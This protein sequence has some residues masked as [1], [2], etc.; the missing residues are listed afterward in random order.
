[1]ESTLWHPMQALADLLTLRDNLGDLPGRR[2]AI[3]WVHSPEPASAAVVHS[4]LHATLRSGMHVQLAHP[5]GFELDGA[6]LS[7]AEEIAQGSGGSLET[8]G[9]AGSA[10]RGAQVVYARSWQSLESYGNATLAPRARVSRRPLLRLVMA[11]KSSTC[12]W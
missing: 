12:S 4:L 8:H 10:V 1:M 5:P 2:L 11:P 7:E 6:V 3:T 9:D